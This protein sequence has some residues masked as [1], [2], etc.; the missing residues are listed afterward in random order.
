[1]SPDT[2]YLVIGCV[3][4]NLTIRNLTIWAPGDSPNTDGVVTGM[5]LGCQK[6][7]ERPQVLSSWRYNIFYLVYL[8]L[9]VFCWHNLKKTEFFLCC[10]SFLVLSYSN[11]HTEL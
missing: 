6:D 9:K 4:S 2:C 1:M 11:H 7:I 3:S 5:Y 10:G 8:I